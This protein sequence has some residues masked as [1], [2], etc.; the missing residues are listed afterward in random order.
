MIK[1]KIKCCLC[2]TEGIASF[3]KIPEMKDK[4]KIISDF[5]YFGR[6]NINHK[7]NEF[8]YSIVFNKNGKVAMGRDGNMKTIK[9]E[10]PKYN[11]KARKKYIEYWE[12]PECFN[13]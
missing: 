9:M 11:P 12:C 10:N 5:K 3:D 7:A 13:E 6:F 4:L 8:Y 1:K 2:G